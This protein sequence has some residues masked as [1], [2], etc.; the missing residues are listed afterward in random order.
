MVLAD[1]TTTFVG[2]F[3]RT[4]SN[5]VSAGRTQMRYPEKLLQCH[6]Q[7]HPGARWHE[8]RALA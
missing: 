2:V 5:N 7:L 3:P 6:I 4:Q 8:W 1:L